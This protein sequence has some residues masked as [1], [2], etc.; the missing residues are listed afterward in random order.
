MDSLNIVPGAVYWLATEDRIIVQHHRVTGF[1]QDHATF[2][3]I[4][5]PNGDI[6]MQ[7]LETGPW[8]RGSSATIGIQGNSSTA[9]QYGHWLGNS[10][11]P[12]RSIYYTYPGNPFR[13]WLRSHKRTA[14]IQPGE[15]F[16]LTLDFLSGDL[17]PGTYFGAVEVRSN[18]PQS[19]TVFIPVEFT[20]TEPDTT[21][22]TVLRRVDGTVLEGGVTA[23][24]REHL[25]AFSPRT[26]TENIVYSV[27][28][29][30]YGTVLINQIPGTQFTQAD[31][32]DGRVT[33]QH[34][35]SDFSSTSVIGFS[36]TD[37]VDTLGPLGLGFA[38][39]PVNDPPTIAGPA[40][41]NAATALSEWL[42]G[43]MV[44]DPDIS[45]IYANWHLTVEVAHGTLHL[46]TNL[47][48]GFYSGGIG[49]VQNNGTRKVTVETWLSRMQTNFGSPRGIRYTSNAG[50]SGT[51]YL[52]ITLNDLGNT[53]VGGP[54]E[55]TLTIPIV[56]YP[57]DFHRWRAD[58]FPAEILSDPLLEE[59]VWGDLAD[60]D[61]DNLPNI[62]E[63]A[64]GLNPL[65]ADATEHLRTGFDGVNF[66]LQ[67][68]RINPLYGYT[69][70]PQWADS[71]AGPWRTNGLVMRT[72]EAND[73][74]TILEA[75]ISAVDDQPRYLRLH[76]VPNTED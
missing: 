4:L 16:T 59:S 41:F 39:S 50:F 20:V 7:Y 6:R 67:Y 27:T 74:Q 57:S 3:T 70:Q 73:Q 33:Y 17:V 15:A 62:M 49:S 38:V 42:P 9:L 53:G 46:S 51:D 61:M 28:D 60:P 64:L 66:W 22:L 21:G 1:F 34:D 65:K 69:I 26:T 12:G 40:Y 48:N 5:Y 19:P 36:L 55:A 54:L 68:P 13:D 25:V 72:V 8:L 10:I 2:Q 37:G 32:D 14:N 58:K 18:D 47:P 24:S 52:T 45:H 35:G 44:D 56:V 75:R 11:V 23:I 29:S 71:P 30:G 76:L 63:Y 43:M 31:I